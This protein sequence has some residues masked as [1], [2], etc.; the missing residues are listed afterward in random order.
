VENAK[1]PLI[2]QLYSVNHIFMQ[3]QLP[4]IF[5]LL[6]FLVSRQSI[7]AQGCVAVRHMSCAAGSGANSNSMMHP[8]QWQ[9]SMGFRNLYSHRHFV[10][11]EYQEQRL[12][13]DTEVKN[14]SQGFDIGITYALTDRLSLSL[15]I[16]LAINARDSKYE[17]YG[18]GTLAAPNPYF[19]TK[20]SGLGDIRLGASYWLFDPM[21]SMNG[22]VSL[23]LGVKAPTGDSN[24]QGDFHKLDKEGKDYIQTKAVDQSIQ[25]GDGG[26][27]VNVEIQGYQKLFTNASVYY[28]G[29]YLFNPRNVNDTYNN[30]LKD[31][32]QNPV[33]VKHSVADQFAARA[34]VA[35]GLLPR[36]GIAVSLGARIEGV[37]AKDVI[38]KSEGF[39]RPGYIISIE[40]GIS[41]M[42]KRNTFALNVPIATTR[43]RVKSYSDLKYGGQGDAA[44]AD[45]FVSATLSHRF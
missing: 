11:T 8:G 40:P 19:T 23:G 25:L 31:N 15:N 20:S 33:T 5:F 16:P 18:N 26:W 17:H 9:V 24:V 4:L 38:G 6:C 45:Y 14:Y 1:L 43:N 41:Y 29:F 28:N 7:F 2:N 13:N 21:K 36:L 39:R 35:Y 32:V 34:G 27:G 44:F 30:I 22:N 3:K 10:G 12:T 37:P 42:N